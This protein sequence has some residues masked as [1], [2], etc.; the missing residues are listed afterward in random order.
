ML[1]QK[2]E[3]IS[4]ILENLRRGREH[5]RRGDESVVEHRWE[6][7]RWGHGDRIEGKG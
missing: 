7:M 5:D 2:S 6:G 3:F 1:L 4:R